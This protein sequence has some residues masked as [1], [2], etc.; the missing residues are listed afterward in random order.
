MIWLK[1]SDYRKQKYIKLR[2]YAPRS[3]K[4]A[5]NFNPLKISGEPDWN[6]TWEE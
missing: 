4:I 5:L 1:P 6:T 3:E 2:L